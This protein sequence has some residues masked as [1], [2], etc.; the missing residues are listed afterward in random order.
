LQET[1]A[2]EPHPGAEGHRPRQLDQRAEPA[3]HAAA[4]RIALAHEDAA[5]CLR[6]VTDGDGHGRDAS[7]RHGRA[8]VEHRAAVG[9]VEVERG[10]RLLLHRHRL[11]GHARS[12]HLERFGLDDAAVGR[13]HVTG[14][15]QDHVTVHEVRRVDLEQLAASA[16]ERAT[17]SGARKLADRP[18]GAVALHAA[19]HGIE[20]DD[21]AHHRR[22]TEGADRGG[23]ARARGEQRSQR[24]E[25][26]VTDGLDELEQG[27]ALNQIDAAASERFLALEPSR[28]RAQAREHRAHV[29]RVPRRAVARRR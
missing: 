10:S 8:L 28:A 5:A 26:L 12:I 24:I 1:R 25:E 23:Q 2:D 9:H 15:E 16:H 7:G 3:L 13:H 17:T 29:E 11:A 4:H 22:V 18:L 21:T 27:G 20:R 14:R 6:F 19:D